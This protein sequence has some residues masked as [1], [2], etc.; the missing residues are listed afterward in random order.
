[1]DAESQPAQGQMADLSYPGK[2]AT[3]VRSG[4][5]RPEVLNLRNGQK[6]EA[7]SASFCCL[8]NHPQILRLKIITIYSA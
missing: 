1:M 2:G 3:S 4:G 6:V 5:E 8:T 7:V